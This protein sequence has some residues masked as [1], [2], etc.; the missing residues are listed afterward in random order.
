MAISLTMDQ[1]NSGLELG[2]EWVR[3]LSPDMKSLIKAFS[4]IVA[5]VFC[6]EV[7]CNLVNWSG[8]IAAES[9]PGILNPV[10]MVSGPV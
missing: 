2:K 8:Q 7:A 1:E 5:V 3:R 4:S 6:F 10:L 9:T